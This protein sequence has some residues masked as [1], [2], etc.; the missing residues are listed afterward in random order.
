M[1]IIKNN[2]N[3][4]FLGNLLI[5]LIESKSNGK[6]LFFN[7]T[8]C[9]QDNNEIPLPI[10][11][12]RGILKLSLHSIEDL[13]LEKIRQFVEEIFSQK[14][15]ASPHQN[16]SFENEIK[17]IE[18]IFDINLDELNE[19][20]TNIEDKWDLIYKQL[21]DFERF[22]K[23]MNLKV[24]CTVNGEKIGLNFYELKNLIQKCKKYQIPPESLSSSLN[25][26]IGE[27]TARKVS[28]SMIQLLNP[29]YKEENF[30]SK[31]M[32]GSGSEENPIKILCSSELFESILH[33]IFED[34]VPDD[35]ALFY[36]MYDYL[37][38]QNSPLREILNKQ[39]AIDCSSIIKNLA[40][41]SSHIDLYH[42]YEFEQQAIADNTLLNIM[43]YAKGSLKK[44]PHQITETGEIVTESK[45]LLDLITVLRRL[46]IHSLNKLNSRTNLS[47]LLA[48]PFLF[49][50]IK[51]LRL[52]LASS[53]ELSL[54]LKNLTHL[55]ELDLSDYCEKGNISS[56]MFKEIFKELIHLR[57]LRIYS[58]DHKELRFQFQNCLKL[59][60]LELQGSG[61]LMEGFE[62][63]DGHT[64]LRRLTLNFPEMTDG[65]LTILVNKS[66][67]LQE[68]TLLNCD[69]LTPEGL[70]KIA[71]LKY[72][73]RLSLNSN[74]LLAENFQLIAK[75]CPRLK[76]LTLTKRRGKTID[77]QAIA[78]IKTLQTLKLKNLAFI[79]DDNILTDDHLRVLTKE[80]SG[81][82]ELSLEGFTDF[83]G[84]SLQFLSQIARLR[85]LNLSFCKQISDHHIQ[86][87]AHSSPYLHDLNLTGC[88]RI[89]DQAFR[90]FA[91]L[92]H[93]RDLN[94]TNCTR[95]TEKGL[96][97]LTHHLANIENVCI[98][99]CI[100]I[101]P[102]NFLQRLP[103]L[104]ADDLKTLFS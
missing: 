36:E 42:S 73:E 78:E 16:N 69:K 2:N 5:D 99:G 83:K 18:F 30:F 48:L 32:M 47:L 41:L 85:K 86:I 20:E 76:E 55:E 102:K 50:T 79:K 22:S 95:I 7:I 15:D 61:N 53:Q 6:Q 68:L 8:K 27:K 103:G 75:G 70:Q 4:N 98:W 89:S 35:E 100:E 80:L 39:F 81:L 45:E 71:L 92:V 26:Q 17:K 34:K 64:A 72:L 21:S 38:T 60:E 88:F 84:E 12:N 31:W 59:E 40:D 74:A 56:E 101:N 57:K 58:I 29:L 91:E 65:D 11:N 93:L 19:K 13:S 104:D 24:K 54:L 63:L 82:E 9:E 66:P 44:F 62:A 52:P 90:S 67:N 1:N 77:F 37:T 28:L 97:V 33:L 10:Q 96:R 51:K 3:I 94:L 46:N 49:S 14:M 43:M 25:V 23:G 87:M